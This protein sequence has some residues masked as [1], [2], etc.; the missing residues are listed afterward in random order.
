MAADIA[1]LVIDMQR[2]FCEPGGYAAQAG[3]D[4]AR[5]RAP[6][7]HIA[8]LL[9]AA[10]AQGLTVVHTREGHRPDLADLTPA[11]RDR[12]AAAGAP[13]GDPG[14]LGRL[15][16]C[17]EY[18]QDI[19]DELAPLPGETVI[20]KPGYSAFHATDLDRHLAAAGIHRLVIAGVTTDVCVH[21]TLRAAVDLGYR[22]TTVA[23][24]CAAADPALHTAA[25]AM[26]R[27]EGG[28]FGAVADTDTVLRAWRTEHPG[29]DA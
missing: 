12:C 28:V 18:G 26:I 21:S 1:L 15:L 7:P 11:K 20:D 25:L 14:P 8:R 23:D 13:V 17:G 9:D 19:V 6:I 29:D 16:V 5:L 10:R 3:L 24:A 4:V 2:D 22:C 27:G